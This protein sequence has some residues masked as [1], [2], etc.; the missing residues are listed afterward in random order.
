MEQLYKL[1]PG[2][3]FTI[4]AKTWEEQFG[5]LDFPNNYVEI[6][7]KDV[8]LRLEG[9]E[10]IKTK[11]HWWQFWKLKKKYYRFRVMAVA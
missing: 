11:R 6:D 5:R 3:V 9:I 7:N 10:K 1:S 8:L 4:D 2:V